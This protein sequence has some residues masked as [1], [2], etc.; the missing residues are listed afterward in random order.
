MSQLEV[1]EKFQLSASVDVEAKLKAL[2][3]VPKDTITFVDWYYD[4]NDNYLTT[5]DCWLRFREKGGK[6]QWQLKRGKGHTSSTVYEETEG[7]D[8]VS[9]ALS[10]M[11][12]TS[13]SDARREPLKNEFEGFEAP[14]LPINEP[15][16]LA[17]FCRLETKRSSWIVDPTNECTVYEGMEVDLDSTNT[18]HTVGEVETIVHDDLNVP[19][20]KARVKAL[21]HELTEKS[22]DGSG[23]AIGKLEHFLMTYRPDH[24]DQCVKCGVLQKT[25]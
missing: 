1:E 4:T 9:L 15:N 13:T 5:H 11:P 25:T 12:D 18:G 2:Q 21:I 24:Y 16:I 7:D 17:P 8:A 3:F 14:E 10:M 6:G 20:A 22:E 19:D 23:V